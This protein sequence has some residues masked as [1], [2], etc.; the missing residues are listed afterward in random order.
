MEN[1]QE[2]KQRGRAAGLDSTTRIRKILPAG[3]KSRLK[4]MRLGLRGRNEKFKLTSKK[5]N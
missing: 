2:V 5:T 4:L 3:L 1:S